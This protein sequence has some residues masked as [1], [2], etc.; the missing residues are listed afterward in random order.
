MR[1]V[2]A[3]VIPLSQ[4][5]R[6]Q[7]ALS[8]AFKAVFITPYDASVST[9][10]TPTYSSNLLFDRDNQSEDSCLKGRGAKTAFGMN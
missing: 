2:C 3:Q 6:F 9:E 10:A 4:K 1:S 5:L 8:T 7:T